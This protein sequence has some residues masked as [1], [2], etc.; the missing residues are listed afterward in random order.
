MGANAK[1]G[2]FL[3]L[4]ILGFTLLPAG[5][6]YLGPLFTIIGLACFVGSLIG[7]MSIKSLEHEPQ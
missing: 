3:F 2:W 1:Q 7:L 4:F 6:V 5:L